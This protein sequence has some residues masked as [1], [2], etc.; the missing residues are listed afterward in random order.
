MSCGS[1]TL[2]VP[3]FACPSSCS[4]P[5]MILLDCNLSRH[6]REITIKVYFDGIGE[7]SEVVNDSAYNDN[8]ERRTYAHS[9][10]ISLQIVFKTCARQT[11]PKSMHM[12]I[13]LRTWKALV[14]SGLLQPRTSSATRWLRSRFSRYPKLSKETPRHHA[15]SNMSISPYHSRS[16]SM[17]TDITDTHTQGKEFFK[18]GFKSTKIIGHIYTYT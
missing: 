7:E 10:T 4:L 6:W 11:I 2:P 5:W 12:T 14:H 1:D 8:V 17:I 15:G 3:L 9:P 16:S 18:N 13:N